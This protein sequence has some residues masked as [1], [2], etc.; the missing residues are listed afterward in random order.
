[1]KIAERETRYF[2]NYARIFAPHIHFIVSSKILQRHSKERETDFFLC[3]YLFLT[4]LE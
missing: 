4:A 2:D 1:M 3:Q